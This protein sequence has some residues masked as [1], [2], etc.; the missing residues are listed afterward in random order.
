MLS[1]QVDS[2]ALLIHRNRKTSSID[3]TSHSVIGVE[4]GFTLGAGQ[5]L[6]K[7]DQ[8]SLLN[9]LL[10]APDDD[11][12]IAEN[13][14]VKSSTKLVW[15]VKAGIYEMDYKTDSGVSRI[16]APMPSMVIE[17]TPGTVRVAAY[18]GKSRPTPET[19]LYYPPVANCYSDSS[20]CLGSFALPHIVSV[21]DMKKIE[22]FVFEGVNTHLGSVNSI[23]GVKDMKGMVAFFE[24]ISDKKAFPVR[25]LVEQPYRANELD[26]WL[27]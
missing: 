9:I 18:K 1:K 27:S 12:F 8:E 2:R 25:K 10:D 3:I 15:Y 11:G 23:A 6:S 4:T 20:V 5:L 14:L 7:A 13:I 22:G 21:K 19:S 26:E 16:K 24:S 17:W